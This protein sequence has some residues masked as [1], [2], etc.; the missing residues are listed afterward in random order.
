MSNIKTKELIICLIAVVAL[1]LT[2]TTNVFATQDIN[3]LMGNND[4]QQVENR[5]TNTSINTNTN[6]NANTNVANNNVNKVAT[7][8]YTG[9]DYSV[10]LIIAICG[11]SAIYAYKKIRD[12][13]V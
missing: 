11:V 12:Y 10:V 8:P 5:N 6:T 1:I 2:I 4:F 7:I 13:N 9:I 3:S